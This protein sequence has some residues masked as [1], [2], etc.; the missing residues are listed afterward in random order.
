MGLRKY[1]AFVFQQVKK[2]EVHK[3]WENSY[4]K[5]IILKMK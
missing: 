1:I 4:K 5:V 2:I 3:K